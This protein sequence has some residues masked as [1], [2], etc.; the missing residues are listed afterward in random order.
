MDEEE[1]DANQIIDLNITKVADI[2]FYTFEGQEI[3][4]TITVENNGNVNLFNIEITDP[5]LNFV[6]N[7]DTLAPG[8][9]LMFTE[10]YFVTAD[11]LANTSIVNIV[12]VTAEDPTDE[13]IEETAEEEVFNGIEGEI[14]IMKSADVSSY[15]M[16]G[17]IIN[18]TLTVENTGVTQLFDVEVSD[19]LTGFTASI[20]TLQPGEVQVFMTSYTVVL[21]DLINGEITNIATVESEDFLGNPVADSDTLTIIGELCVSPPMWVGTLPPSM[22]VDCDDVPDPALLEAENDCDDIT[23]EFEEVRID[24]NCDYNYVLIR[25]WTAT[26]LSGLSITHEQ[27]LTVIDEQRQV[28][29]ITHP[30]FSNIIGGI[31]E[32]ECNA[33]DESWIFPNLTEDDVLVVDNC[34]TATVEV[35]SEF[36]ISQSCTTSGFL[37]E[38]FYVITAVDECDNVTVFEFTLR[39]VD[40]TPP[41]IVGI[42]NDTIVNCLNIPLPPE[43]GECDSDESNLIIALDNCECATLHFEEILSNQTCEFNFDILRRWTGH[44]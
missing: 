11:N 30:L 37:L 43:M 14:S 3:Q 38:Q 8:E 20:P 10:S 40:N 16:V 32:I 2:E 7:Q 35:E 17:Q 34:G 4:Y 36:E 29:T 33:N 21:S 24:G 25:T 9:V 12:N 15:N 42:P 19:P 31:L 27:T 22:T 41:V 26:T 23:I 5:L 28:I 6:F 1:V 18:Y 39:L 44:G 13:Q